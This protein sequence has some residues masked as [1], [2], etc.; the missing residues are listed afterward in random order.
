MNLWT[1]DIE[2]S[3]TENSNYPAKE[4]KNKKINNPIILFICYQIIVVVF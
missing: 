2:K 4:T 3:A 1:V